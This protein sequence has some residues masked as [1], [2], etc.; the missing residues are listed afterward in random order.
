MLYIGSSWVNQLLELSY[1][2]LLSLHFILGFQNIYFQI[3]RDLSPLT[4]DSFYRLFC[5]ANYVILS[6]YSL[7]GLASFEKKSCTFWEIIFFIL[8]L[9]C[10]HCYWL[11]WYKQDGVYWCVLSFRHNLFQK[12]VMAHVAISGDNLGMINQPNL[13]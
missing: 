5:K 11:F 1:S 2:L 7:L 9:C 13:N 10:H 4:L 3:N 8:K 6:A 12:T